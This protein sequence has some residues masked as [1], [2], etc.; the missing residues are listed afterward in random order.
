[1]FFIPLS[2]VESVELVIHALRAAGG[3]VDC[4]SCP[5]HRVCMK[6]CLTVA[7]A[8]DR[9]VK[10]GTLPVI[11]ADNEP[12]PDPPGASPPTSGTPRTKPER[13]GLKIV[14]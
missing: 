13:G 12:D 5:A 8:I 2:Q 3:E 9:M 10:T 14:K 11:D 1:M 4:T 7:D 6:Q